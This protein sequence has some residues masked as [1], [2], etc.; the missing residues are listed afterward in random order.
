M[1]FLCRIYVYSFVF[2]PGRFFGDVPVFKIPG[3]TFPVNTYFS[4]VPCED[5]LDSC[6]KQV[7][8]CFSGVNCL[9]NIC[10]APANSL[11]ASCR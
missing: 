1:A 3:R 7:F 5:Y 6:V 8:L 2:F 10:L 4:K 9:V 11:V